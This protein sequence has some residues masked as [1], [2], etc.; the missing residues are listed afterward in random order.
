[1]RRQTIINGPQH[2]EVLPL[3]II[4]PDG[5]IVNIPVSPPVRSYSGFPDMNVTFM[6][7]MYNQKY[8]IAGNFAYY[9]GEKII[10]PGL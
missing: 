5:E 10:I 2:G 7:R 9:M 4:V 3:D 6:H 1:M 8:L